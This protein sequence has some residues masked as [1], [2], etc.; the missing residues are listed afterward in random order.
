LPRSEDR[1]NQ[2]CLSLSNLPL[3]Y[4]TFDQIQVFFKQCQVKDGVFEEKSIICKPVENSFSLQISEKGSELFPRWDIFI[5]AK[6]GFSVTPEQSFVD[7]S[8]TKA[9][10]RI[11]NLAIFSQ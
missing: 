9:I 11:K 4:E 6:S 7:S 8:P 5:E 2:R 3:F 10:L 1:S